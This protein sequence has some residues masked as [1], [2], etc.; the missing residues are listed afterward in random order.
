MKEIEW[1]ESFYTGVRKLDD[2][3]KK[4]I[5]MINKLI[6]MGDLEVN[7]ESISNTLQKMTEYSQE[8]F[9]TEEKFMLEYNYPEYSTQ[10]EQH[11]EFIKKTA[12]FCFETMNY[13][14]SVPKEILIYLKEW[15]V[16]HI[17]ASDMKYKSFFEE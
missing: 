2:Q 13:K 17:L 14:T 7:S 8:H 11:R 4:I 5:D 10:K 12:I 1:N 9:D 16:S 15:W 6:E 3:H